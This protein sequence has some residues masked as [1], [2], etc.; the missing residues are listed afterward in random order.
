M[1]S[2]EKALGWPTEEK[3]SPPTTLQRRMR[4]SAPPVAR[5]LLLGPK[6]TALTSERWASYGKKGGWGL[7]SS[8][9]APL[10]AHSQALSHAPHTHQ[11]PSALQQPPAPLP[12]APCLAS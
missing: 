4:R 12:I 5:R 6:Q 10:C 7:W 1:G 3:P 9:H 2:G 11:V 8:P